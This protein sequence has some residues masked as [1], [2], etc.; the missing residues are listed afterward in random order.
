[1]SQSSL[2]I[3]DLLQVNKSQNIAH[4]SV[5]ARKAPI[6]ALQKTPGRLRAIL[7]LRW[8]KPLAPPDSFL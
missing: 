5:P 1:M 4:T 7:A 8:L 3:S 2:S 6:L